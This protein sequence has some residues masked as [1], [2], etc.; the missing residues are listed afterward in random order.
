ASAGVSLQP[1]ASAR[2]SPTR[3]SDTSSISCLISCSVRISDP[4]SPNRF[5]FRLPVAELFNPVLVGA[6]VV[7]ELVEHGDPDLGLEQLR[8]FELAHERAP[9]DRDLVRHVLIRLPEA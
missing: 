9:E 8:V 4:T 2:I 5:L 6:E 3:R 7:G 1:S